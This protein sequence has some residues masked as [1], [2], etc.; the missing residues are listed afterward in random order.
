MQGFYWDA[1]KVYLD[2]ETFKIIIVMRNGLEYHS[3]CPLNE[4]SEY[5]LAKLHLQ[6]R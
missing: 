1:E 3:D 4:K 6:V 5:N 2:I